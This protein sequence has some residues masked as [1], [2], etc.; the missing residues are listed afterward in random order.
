MSAAPRILILTLSFGAGH[1]SAARNVA[2]EIR[3]RLPAA[4]V[5]S[6][7]ALENCSLPFR[8]LY[9]WTYWWMIRYA[10]RLWNRFFRARLERRDEQ[11]APVWMWQKG[12]RKVFAEIERFQPDA[13]VA[14][15]VGASEIAVI[16]R[17]A[18]LTRA[19]IVN[20]ITDFEAEPIWVKPEI[21]AFAVPNREVAAQLQ[22]WGANAAQIKIC[23][24]PLDASFSFRHDSEKVKKQFDLDEKPVVLLM[25]G[26]MG[27]TVMD[28][29]AARL[30][31]KGENLNVVALVGRDE[32][33]RRKLGKLSDSATVNLK[34]LN[35][36]NE[37]VAL[38]QAAWILVTKPGGLTLSEA[39]ACGVPL[40]FF[41]A[42]PGPEESNAELF[43]AAGA[44]VSTRG[45]SATAAEVLRLLKNQNE[46]SAMAENC[47]RLARPNAAAA[48]AGLVL[49]S[50]E[51]VP[52]TKEVYQ[53]KIAAADFP[54][55][56]RLSR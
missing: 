55:P 42:I 1:L 4:E 43:A 12:C 17:R 33:A 9:V 3:R 48:I 51:T 29:V 37:V 35:W 54:A 49:E 40:V 8:A 44:G 2:A 30:L 26:G 36:T 13:I 10:P 15:E 20:V 24:I 39:A 32:R 45:A 41:D 53:V 47:R 5:R 14:A 19:P 25:G 34:I 11:T 16:A 6:I 46:L 21:A 22:N 56:V 18:H 50:I 52:K 31:E 28:E 27:P 23:G 7:D 38:M